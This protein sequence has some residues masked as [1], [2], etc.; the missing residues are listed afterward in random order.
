MQLTDYINKL[1]IEYYPMWEPKCYYKARKKF[2]SWISV[3]SHKKKIP[4]LNYKKFKPLEN[5][6]QE[7]QP[8]KNF[9]KTMTWTLHLRLQKQRRLKI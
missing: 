9:L 8:I 4:P 7:I 2:K 1:K 5:Y 6:F 3:H